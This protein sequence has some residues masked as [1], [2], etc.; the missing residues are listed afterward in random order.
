M[1]KIIKGLPIIGP[2]GRKVYRRLVEKPK[3]FPGSESYW[4]E[5]YDSGGDSGRGSYNHL[6]EFK[7][8]IINRFVRENK[9]TNI[10]EYG[11]GDGNQLKL[12]QYP[13]YIGFD[14]SPKALSQ[15]KEIFR[16]DNTKIFK[17]TN[18]YD[19]ETAQLTLSL[20]VIYHLI[21][22]EIF[23]H[24]IKR[25]FDSSEKFVIIYS[26]NTADNT[27]NQPAHIKHRIFTNW[28]DE[29]RPHWRLVC[30]IPNRYPYGGDYYL[31]SFSDF[32]I[33]EKDWNND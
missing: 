3:P 27:G 18:Q 17:F 7:A 22:E 21:E 8:E 9:I 15:C 32:Y 11:C 10:I 2:I 16:E 1:K 23:V 29:N 33:F 12:A 31:G 19:E 24:Y 5:R 6:A 4:I 20:D 25:L 28:V 14:V 26:S 30:H 13:S